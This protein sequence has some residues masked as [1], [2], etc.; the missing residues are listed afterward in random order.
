M[1][2]NIKTFLYQERLVIFF[3]ALF[4][5]A[6]MI[7]M[8]IQ[9]GKYNSDDLRAKNTLITE[10]KLDTLNNKILYEKAFEDQSASDCK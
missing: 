9:N 8:P 7:V 6:A 3:I 10:Y 2:P 1:S 4:A 5:L